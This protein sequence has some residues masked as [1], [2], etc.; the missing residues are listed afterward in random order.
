MN[1]TK[2]VA[3]L[4]ILTATTAVGQ[5][6]A[7]AAKAAQEEGISLSFPQT[8]ELKTVIDYVSKRLNLNIIYDDAVGQTRV[9][10]TTP[11]KVPED[12][13]LPM[14]KRLLKLSSLELIDTPD[15]GWK[16]V[17]S[18]AVV[19]FVTVR[20][21]NAT[22]LAK[23]INTILEHRDRATGGRT[24]VAPRVAGPRT[25]SV[26]AAG[27]N[28]S[29]VAD[30]KTQQIAVIGAE[31]AV[32][33]AEA[34]IRQMDVAPEI[35]TRTYRLR[36]VSPK[37]LDTLM[38]GQSEAIEMQTAYASTLDEPSGLLIVTAS[39]LLHRQLGQLVSD[40][41]VEADPKRECME[42][43]KLTNAA[44]AEVLATIRNLQTGQSPA[45]ASAHGQTG[46]LVAQESFLP[47][48]PS[49]ANRPSSP[50]M[51][52]LP[53]PPSHRP[54]ADQ[55]AAAGAATTQPS[56][57][58][59]AGIA[60]TLLQGATVT[61][62]VNT[63]TI[64]V[65]APPDVQKVYKQLISALDRRRP[66]VLVELTLVTLNTADNFTLGVE[67]SKSKFT[68]DNQVLV[69]SSFGL[70]TMNLATGIPAIEPGLGF[71]GS[72]V[73]PDV[74][75]AVVQ[76]LTTHSRARVLSAPKILMNDNATG[77]LASVAEQPFVSVNAS[78]TVS[79]TSFAGYASAGT[80]VTVT[81]HISEGDHLQLEYSVALNSFTGGGSEGIPPPR[82]T[83]SLSSSVT[84]PNGFAVIVGGLTRKDAGTSAAGVPFLAEI[85]ILK[86][87][88]GV[89]ST[90]DSQS[91]LFVFIR[92][93]VLRDDQFEDLK[94]LSQ[95][96][97]QAAGLPAN[98]PQS[99]PLN[100]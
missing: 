81:P 21:A 72:L 73:S 90:T 18:K 10:L 82:Q 44:A 84:V 8:V 5:T 92:P 13:L 67:L 69:F 11:A 79:T 40:L 42:F 59:A 77:V 56:G 64:I 29:L 3:T 93:I 49:G 2:V 1:V 61:A 57:G 75:N 60:S 48:T 25:G 89:H 12:Q 63:N 88:F 4:C 37:R 51:A 46:E 43:H 47:T 15:P 85:P 24:T 17:G 78:N 26:V 86:Y 70:S 66:Q 23:R 52:T 38:R 16:T 74:F 30:A 91:T 22:D 14:L 54:K 100:M 95:Q 35:Q 76:A 68:N 19:R 7:P 28:V 9:S 80:T 96:D 20:N 94:Y 27:E 87:L 31:D 58:S 55:G 45:P 33:D 32:A 62:D 34:L 41:D 53:T 83:D 65:V 6:T 50:G 97:L 71:N 99:D 36:F 39:E 98:F